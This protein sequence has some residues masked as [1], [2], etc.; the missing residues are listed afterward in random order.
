MPAAACVVEAEGSA[1]ARAADGNLN[2]NQLMTIDAVVRLIRSGK[3]LAITGVEEALDQLPI[4]NWIG[5]TAPHL[6]DASL[7]ASTD[8]QVFVSELPA[9]GLTSVQHYDLERMA[10]IAA[11]APAQG[12]SL[13]IVPDGGSAHLRFASGF[14]H[15]SGITPR[16]TVG[17]VATVDP[18]RRGLRQPLVYFGKT[19]Q[20]LADGAVVAHAR[21]PADTPLGDGVARLMAPRGLDV[22]CFAH[23][24]AAAAPARA[25]CEAALMA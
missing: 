11:H 10:A 13:V 17:W 15:G 5:G 3:A 6:R 20:K 9:Q 1:Q 16:P 23:S 25:E 12:Y 19:G 14:G 18:A 22:L 21:V 4:G 2:V 7:C 24:G 8:R